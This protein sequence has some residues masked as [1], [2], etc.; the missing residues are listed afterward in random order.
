MQGEFS[1]LNIAR[2]DTGFL[3]AGIDPG[4]TGAIAWLTLD[5]ALVDVED[6]PMAEVKVGKGMRKRLVPAILATML[7]DRRP[8]HV[9][10]EEVATRPGEGP[11]GAFAFGRGFGQLEGLLAGVGISYTLVRPQTWKA[12]LH[13]PA[14]KGSARMIACR[15]WPTMAPRFARVKDDGKAESALIGLYGVQQRVR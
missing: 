1:A 13:V 15:L 6:L 11:V 12:K 5:G 3:M 8:S 2:N 9:Y 7:A 4:V 14:D 10:I